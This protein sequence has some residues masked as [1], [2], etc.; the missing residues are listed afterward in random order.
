EI[1]PVI[2]PDGTSDGIATFAAARST[3]A[4]VIS[5]PPGSG[6]D[7]VLRPTLIDLAP[8]HAART[9]ALGEVV[10]GERIDHRFDQDEFLVDVPVAQEVEL[11]LSSDV[12]D[13]FP[14]SVVRLGSAASAFDGSLRPPIG[15]A[16]LELGAS[17]RIALEAGRYAVRFSGNAGAAYRF[18]LRTVSP[19]P[20]AAAEL[21]T[22][23]DTVAESIDYVGD[24]D[25]FLLRGTPGAEYEVFVSAGGSAPHQAQVL[26]LGLSQAAGPYA[27][28]EPG[29]FLLDSA[30]GRFA[31]P[32][33]GEV[34]VRVRDWWD[35]SGGLYRGPYR[36]VAVAIDRRPEGR[37]D[38]IAPSGG[39]IASA[40]ELYGDVDEYRFTLDAPTRVA[41]RCAPTSGGGCGVYSAAVYR[42]DAPGPPVSLDDL[43]PLAA[44]SYRLRVESGHGLR[45]SPLYRGPY[46]VVLARVDTIPEDVAPSL[47]IGATVSES[48]SWPWDIDTFTLDVTAADTLIVRLDSV[49]LAGSYFRTAVTDLLTG[50]KL[51]VDGTYGA[52]NRRIDPVPG[53]YAVAVS[54]FTSDW[55]P[56][57]ARTYRLAVER[58]SAAPEGRPVAVAVGDTLR[59]NFDYEGDVDDYV[60]TGAPWEMVSFTLIPEHASTHAGLEVVAVRATEPTSGA[61]LGITSSFGYYALTGVPVEIPSGGAVKLRV[62]NFSSCSVEHYIGPYTI[63]V[64]HVNGPPESRPSAFAVGDTV[65]EALESGADVDEFTFGG[66]AGQAVDV[67]GLQAP[68]TPD[69]TTGAILEV[70]DQSGNAR[71]AGLSIRDGDVRTMSAALRGLVLPTTGRYLVRIRSEPT[72]T[73]QYPAGAY[74]FVISGSAAPP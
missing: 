64:N 60:L 50:R 19:R 16:E 66:T 10:S 34:T 71:I 26:L 24:Y 12:G 56:D 55:Q 8:E 21:L 48:A 31:M 27:S 14:A 65:M 69:G 1:N 2:L 44:G 17:G 33:N 9:I 4:I 43:A 67:I 62:C 57:A 73:F 74:R 36:L 11:Y 51:G 38:T 30:T 35:K 61:T 37:A 45:S 53:R 68:T 42:D 18:Q 29:G 70:F 59:S 5:A 47:T 6:G 23:G 39:V 58:A 7:F 25:D 32:A 63:A 49:G 41:L 46:Q 72:A 52:A 13:Y 28:A 54:A 15:W 40:L 20:E 3:Y 22:V